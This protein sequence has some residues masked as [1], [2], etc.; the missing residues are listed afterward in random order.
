MRNAP[1]GQDRDGVLAFSLQ[2]GPVLTGS[3]HG[4]VLCGEGSGMRAHADPAAVADA[5][6]PKGCCEG[7]LRHAIMVACDVP[8]SPVKNSSNNRGT[9]EKLKGKNGKKSATR[10][11]RV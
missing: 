5:L 3:S 2:C 4:L 9:L 6:D 1:L 11:P 8:Q 10:K 7:P